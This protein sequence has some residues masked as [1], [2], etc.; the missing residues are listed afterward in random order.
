MA[1]E[2]TVKE[3][4][5]YLGR[6]RMYTEAMSTLS[7]DGETIAPPGSVEARAKRAGFFGLEIFNMVTAEKMG[8]FLDELAPH[9]DT[10]DDMLKGPELFMPIIRIAQI[11]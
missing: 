4:K 6:I 5:E 3:F 8:N 7:F 1:I 2:N 10:F 9:F 11:A